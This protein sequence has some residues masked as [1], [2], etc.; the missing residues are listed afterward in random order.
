MLPQGAGGEQFD[1]LK[2]ELVP[3]KIRKPL[4]SRRYVFTDGVGPAP[5]G[6]HEIE[7][8]ALL[9][10]AVHDT[11]ILPLSGDP[12]R[13]PEALIDSGGFGLVAFCATPDSLFVEM[14]P[15]PALMARTR[16]Q[17]V[18]VRSCCVRS[19]AYELLVPAS[20]ALEKLPFWSTSHS[21]MYE[22]LGLFVFGFQLTTAMPQ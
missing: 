16:N 12:P 1:A 11:R 19:T 20:K 3:R 21:T 10:G 6:R 13:P 4:I 18:C 7:P 5:A 8:P 17:N 9:T 15:P 22:A 14:T 2:F